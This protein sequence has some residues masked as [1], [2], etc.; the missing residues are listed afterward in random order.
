MNHKLMNPIDMFVVGLG[1]GIVS[2]LLDIGRIP[3]HDPYWN[4]GSFCSGIHSAI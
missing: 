3:R 1:L 2:R 4:R